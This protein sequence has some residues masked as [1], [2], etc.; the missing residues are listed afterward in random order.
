MLVN[1]KGAPRTK[2]TSSGLKSARHLDAIHARQQ[3]KIIRKN[4]QSWDMLK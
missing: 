4:F 1:F 3:Q 2:V